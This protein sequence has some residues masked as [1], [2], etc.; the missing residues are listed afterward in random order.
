[1][2]DPGGGAAAELRALL[3]QQSSQA[4]LFQALQQLRDS[5]DPS[6]LFLRTILEL[7]SNA[8]NASNAN[9]QIQAAI[10]PIEI[11]LLPNSMLLL[12]TGGTASG[13]CSG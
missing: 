7:T 9:T 3:G 2:A 12:Y 5:G 1:M 6:F 10:A 4:A 11:R 8:S 13:C